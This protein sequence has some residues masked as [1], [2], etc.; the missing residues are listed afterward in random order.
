M[1][2]WWYVDAMD[3]TKTT[4]RLPHDLDRRLKE[5][6]ERNRRSV[7][8]QMLVYIERGLDQDRAQMTGSERMAER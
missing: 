8:A 5:A 1:S 3:E 7:H 6:A 2:K 4:I